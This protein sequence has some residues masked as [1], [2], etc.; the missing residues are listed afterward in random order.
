MA[1]AASQLTMTVPMDESPLFDGIKVSK[2]VL[3][4]DIV[5]S[6]R[7]MEKNED[8]TIRRWRGMLDRITRS[9]LATNR[10]R[11]VKGTGD[12]LIAE[13]DH[14]ADALSAAFSMHALSCEANAGR[15]QADRILLRIGCHVADVVAHHNDIYGHGVNLTARLCA[16]AGPGEIVVSADFRDRITASLDGDIEDLG[17]CFLKHVAQPMRAYRVTAPGAPKKSRPL[18]TERARNDLRA[19]I[20]V[21]P[22]RLRDG[23]LRH[24]VLGEVLA[25]EVIAA[26]S[27]SAELHVISRLSTTPFR[28][29]AA[30]AS[31][32]SLHLGTAYVLSGA[33]VVNRGNLHLAAELT[34]ANNNAVVWADSIAAPARSLLDPHNELVQRL[35]AEASRAITSN[36]MSRVRTRPLPTLETYALLMAGIALMHRLSLADFDRARILLQTVAD[37]APREPIPRAWLAKWH[38]LRVNQGWTDNAEEDANRALDCTN[39]ALDADPSCSLALAISGFVHTNLRMQFDVATDFY[40]QAISANPNDSLAWLL[41]GT[42][43]AF[44][45]EAAPAV[46]GTE[47]ALQLSPLDPLRYFYDSLAATAAM[48]AGMFD[49][50]IELAQRSLRANRTHTSTWRALAIAQVRSGRVEAGRASVEQLRKIEPTLTASSYL[51]R[52]PSGAFNTGK[53]WADALVQAGLPQ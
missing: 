39:R 49:R 16:L 46:E 27:R 13:F 14:A 48:S 10:G 2:V 23:S 12:G 25:D 7:L 18:E 36:E 20:A 52:N 41:K 5:E 33:Y 35:V 1:D 29:R 3:V 19:S 21:I 28:D 9:I 17:D 26:L 51:R 11:L 4:T 45:G 47:K 31:E 8:E 30:S 37:R 32:I 22:F 43:H 38:V 40:E 24:A 53:V 42:L 44:K 34:S 50:A 6:V 15:A